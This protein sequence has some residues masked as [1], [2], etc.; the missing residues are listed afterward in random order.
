MSL[1]GGVRRL[2]RLRDPSRDVADE[3]SF[4]FE[5]VVAELRSQGLTESEAR[6][7]AERR[8]GDVAAYRRE[9]ESL[10]GGRQR[11]ERR[12]NRTDALR[13]VSVHALR[14]VR[15]APT[16][17]AA[18][19]LTLG[20][21]LGAN[22][23]VYGIVDRLLLTPPAHVAEPEQV[24]RL[25]IEQYQEWRGE[26][27]PA[28][29][30]AWLDFADIAEA[31]AVAQAAAWQEQRLTVGHGMEARQLDGMAVS[32]GYFALR[33]VQ[34]SLGRLL[35]PDDDHA[36]AD[37]VAVIS[38]ALWQREYGGSPDALGRTLSFGAAPYTI[39]GVAPRG[40]TSLRLQNIDVWMPVHQ[41]MSADILGTRNWHAFSAVIRVR[42]DVSPAAAMDEMSLL[43][44][45]GR[46][47]QIAAGR[48]DAD[49]RALLAPVLEARGPLAL[50]EATV[51]RW[52]AAV[53]LIVLLIACVNVAN[54]LLARA[55][56]QR[57]ELAVRLA[58]GISRTRLIAQQM[59]EGTILGLAGGAVA[60][61]LAHW[62]GPVVSTM[63]LPD[64]AWRE[65]A[66]P[67]LLLPLTL[68]VAAL[69]GALAALVPA[70][71]MSSPA[72]ADTLRQAASGGRAT[73]RMR[74]MLSLAQAALSVVLLV[75]AG[76][77]V[78]SLGAVQAVDLG[79][80]MTDLLYVETR[81]APGT[82]TEEER[83]RLRH[84]VVDRL[85]EHPSIDAAA[86]ANTAPFLW[87]VSNNVRLPGRDT[88]PVIG[89]GDHWFYTVSPDYFDLLGIRL[90]RGRLFTE[91]DAATG[92]N[93]AVISETMAMGLWPDSD[94]LGSCMYIDAAVT[95]CT[96]VV[97][98][99][100]D[101]KQ[102]YV[103]EEG[104]AQYYLPLTARHNAAV[105]MARPRPGAERPGD[106]IRGAITQLDGR[107]RFV[108]ITPAANRFAPQV[109]SWRMG[110]TLFTGFGLLALLVAALG[111]YAVLAFDV[112]QRTREIGVRGA[113]GAG[114][115]D[116]LR[117]VLGNALRVAVAGIAIGGVVAALLAPRLSD[118]LFG[119]GPHD[120]L[121]YAVV[122]AALLAVAVAAALLPARRATAI[123]PNQALRME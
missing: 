26:R 112:T 9:L 4:H 27:R 88:L 32:G 79:Y 3:L 43:L 21:G 60:L 40:L 57:R 33:G 99:V 90:L 44:R 87:V 31:R 5:H 86:A 16:L 29:H 23:T 22:V 25:L 106:A 69:A 109:R 6:G 77:F 97:G 75:G 118:M 48:F 59:L 17:S 67:R 73:A 1:P 70:L 49:A 11:A 119:V 120:A 80:D 41:A 96:F 36:Q 39:V 13:D 42:D 110:A 82:T 58:L 89:T 56:R 111:L 45:Q 63:L 20:L 100:R 76:L 15:R 114:R 65:L 52:L 64:I 123:D 121:T 116:I 107:I 19:I 72:L 122:A 93:V 83:L 66:A 53:S 34:P 103:R 62:I 14:S 68:A 10:A 37:R 38:H 108:E 113:L 94:A 81:F 46:A 12:T 7:E 18:I 47:E 92:A 117:L 104:S 84:A 8:F 61:L 54:L 28:E 2:L 102:Q 91:R 74:A 35:S 30:M 71:R 115:G 55:V 95:E 101:T 105:V 24:H 50:P 85:R 51:A 78:R 98:I